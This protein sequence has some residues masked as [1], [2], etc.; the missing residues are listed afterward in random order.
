MKSTTAIHRS[1]IS[2]NADVPGDEKIWDI[3]NTIRIGELNA[4]P[5]YGVATDDSH[6]YHGGD[7]SPGRGWIVVGAEQ[8]NGD[9]LIEAMKDGRFYA[10]SGVHLRTLDYDEKT[11]T[12]SFTIE[13]DGDAYFTTQMIGSRKGDT[14]T[15]EIGEV[16]ATMAGRKISYV[17]PEDV[18]YIRTTITSSKRHPQSLFSRSEKTGLAPTGGLVID[19]TGLKM[20]HGHSWPFAKP[21]TPS[22]TANGQEGPFHVK[23]LCSSSCHSA[24]AGGF[25]GSSTGSNAS[26]SMLVGAMAPPETMKVIAWSM[27]QSVGVSRSTGT[28]SR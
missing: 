24:E 18:L 16:F 1:T 25:S 4:A 28:I 20:W 26:Y 8:L 23:G 15:I 11:R 9:S 27:L 3:A 2:G 19:Q 13:A 12:L 17:V 21:T 7:V 22:S 5:L 10:S 14:K 6:T